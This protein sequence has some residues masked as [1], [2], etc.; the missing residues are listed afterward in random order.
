MRKQYI[1]TRRIH[2]LRTLPLSA[3]T[4]LLS[5]ICLYGRCPKVAI[6]SPLISSLSTAGG[7]V[8]TPA[9]DTGHYL[10]DIITR[11]SQLFKTNICV[12][13]PCIVGAVCPGL[14]PL[15]QNTI[16]P[17]ICFQNHHV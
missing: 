13:L 12:Y 15:L 9:T 3:D 17:E 2:V 14:R 10:T 5:V 4:V 7:D 11:P 16:S 6:A 1:I 8:P